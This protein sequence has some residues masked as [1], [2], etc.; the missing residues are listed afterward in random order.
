MHHKRVFFFFTLKWKKVLLN[1]KIFKSITVKTKMTIERR[2]SSF[3][4]IRFS[5]SFVKGCITWTMLYMMNKNFIYK[6]NTVQKIRTT[7]RILC[8]LWCLNTKFLFIIKKFLSVVVVL[9]YCKLFRKLIML[10]GFHL[11]AEYRE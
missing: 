4:F 7:V 8:I 2:F 11:P 3:F 5:E 1:N 6:H 10:Y 9:F